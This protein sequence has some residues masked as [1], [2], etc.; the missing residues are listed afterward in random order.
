M[1]DLFGGGGGFDSRGSVKS[2]V[3]SYYTY[4]QTSGGQGS[5]GGGKGCGST[6]LI[7]IVVAAAINNIAATFIVLGCLAMLALLAALII[8]LKRKAALKHRQTN[9]PES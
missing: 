4:T 8:K 7:V 3:D 9:H 6:V 2:N 5:S 1:S